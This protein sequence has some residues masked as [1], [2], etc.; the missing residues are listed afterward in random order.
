MQVIA[1]VDNECYPI[2]LCNDKMRVTS[3]LSQENSQS[4]HLI[5]K[6]PVLDRLFCI[7][8]VLFLVY[9]EVRLHDSVQKFPF[10]IAD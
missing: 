4:Y 5:L 6:Y 9:H 3:A 2:T 8:L 10:L 1:R 7:A